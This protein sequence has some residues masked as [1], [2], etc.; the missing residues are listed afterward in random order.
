[1]CEQCD[2]GKML[3]SAGVAPTDNRLK[4]LKAVGDSPA[5][6]RADD[7]QA[8]VSR[9]GPINRVTVYRI[10]DLLFQKGLV[11]RLSGGGRSSF[12]GLAPNQHHRRHPHFFCRSCGNLSCMAP[13]SASVDTTSL[14]A[15]CPGEI[16]AV[17]VHVEGI[18]DACARPD[19]AERG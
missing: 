15:N 14:E 16:E 10:L 18:C 7:I 1:M 3:R 2:Y 11:E 6:L 19:D 5:P 17:T 12:F 8:V 4:V 9:T 13:D